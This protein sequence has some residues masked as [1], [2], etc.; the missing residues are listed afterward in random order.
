MSFSPEWLSLRE[1]ADHA[2]RDKELLAEVGDYF[3]GRS[4]IRVTDIGCGAG[5]NLRGTYSA[6]PKEQFWRLVDYDPVLLVAARAKLITWADRVVADGEPLVIEKGGK[7]LTIRFAEANLAGGYEAITDGTPDLVTAAALFDL[8]SSSWLHGLVHALSADKLPLYTSLTY[9]GTD[10]WSPPHPLDNAV[11]AAFNLHQ[12]TDKGFGKAAGPRAT[13]V[14]VDGFRK[15]GYR[16]STGTSPWV[17]D[18]AH[19]VLIEQLAIGIAAAAG[20]TGR[21]GE[22]ELAGWLAA[23]RLG[24]RCTVGH[25]DLFAVPIS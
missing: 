13:G 19:A 18:E 20:E 14:L 16:A 24:A 21:I 6:L 17:L 1:P 15:D 2:A 23:R 9:D 5:S 10:D 7:H 22:F 25:Q 4:S 3:A 11:R 12:G 8:V